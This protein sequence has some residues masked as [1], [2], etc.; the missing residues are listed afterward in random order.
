MGV[1]AMS[2]FTTQVRYLCESFGGEAHGVRE[3]DNQIKRAN[4]TIFDFDY[5]IFDNSY[6]EELELK[7]IRHYYMREIGAETFGLWQLYLCDK[8]NEIMPYYNQLYTSTLLKLE[9]LINLSTSN[10]GT[11]NENY[12]GN[13]ITG[14]V[15]GTSISEST[16]SDATD[17]WGS[18]NDR[19]STGQ[20]TSDSTNT[21]SSENTS[22]TISTPGVTTTVINS[23]SSSDS[24]SSSSTNSQTSPATSTNKSTSW[25][26]NSDTPQGGLT[27]ITGGTAAVSD[28]NIG[29]PHGE[30]DYASSINESTNT[31]KSESSA[32]ASTSSSSASGSSQN[33][34]TNTTTVAGHD[35]VQNSGSSSSNAYSAT[36]DGTTEDAYDQR[37]GSDNHSGNI[38]RTYIDRVS[39]D[40]THDS[41]TSRDKSLYN[42]VKG[43]SG[44]S[45]SK[46]LQEWRETF[47]NI[48]K[49]IIEDLGVL[50][51]GLYE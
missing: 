24:S 20:R 36:K 10:V 14:N 27:N 43:L 9:P 37:S 34:S 11:E 23:G 4:R 15:K 42:A 46:L 18:R 19:H 45:Q 41:T 28:A 51:F 3:I 6:K 33:S 38:A 32:G 13:E 1:L 29:A 40:T 39:D 21:S 22:G 35:D 5:P 26:V 16:V 17:K 44:V 31:T 48:D 25:N 8:M 12:A 47:L 50:F 49:Q 7:I 30:G 2:N